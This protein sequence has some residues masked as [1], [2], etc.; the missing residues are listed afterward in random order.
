MFLL[1]NSAFFLKTHSSRAFHTTFINFQSVSVPS[2]PSLHAHLIFSENDV[3][4]YAL[5]FLS[6]EDIGSKKIQD[7]PE[8]IVGWSPDPNVL[9]HHT[10]RENHG[11]VNFL[12]Q[13]FNRQL[14][15]VN[16]AH[17]KAMAEW[18]KEGWMHIN[19]ERD[20]PAWGRINFPEDI[21]GSVQ[22]SNGIILPHSY[23]PMPTHRLITPK[24]LFK[25][26]DPLT[27]CVADA[28]KKKLL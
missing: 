27:H 4:Q 20:P 11:F 24:G 15:K 3:K 22:V 19:D 21:I 14:H 10:F 17:L 23:Q 13:T 9:D 7:F 8:L 5:S 18:Q 26:S 28:S 12:T 6:S 2:Q 25:L 16:D 1:K